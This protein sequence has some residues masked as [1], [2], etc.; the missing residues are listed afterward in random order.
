MCQRRAPSRA[1][2]AVGHAGGQLCRPPEHSQRLPGG[3]CPG[4]GAA[5]CRGGTQGAVLLSPTCQPP[6]HF[7][8]CLKAA[9]PAG[10]QGWPGRRTSV[11]LSSIFFMADSV[12][13]GYLTIWNASSFCG[14]GA[15][16]ERAH[17]RAQTLRE[18]SPASTRRARPSV[19]ATLARP[20][21]TPVLP[22]HAT[23]KF[24]RSQCRRQ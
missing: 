16:R 20:S 17:T 19:C 22:Y 2:P 5:G 10:P 23:H 14:A 18:G 13:S 24:C 1:Q 3:R 9:V 4:E 7:T 11:L 21:A 12:V 6:A 15:L 8:A